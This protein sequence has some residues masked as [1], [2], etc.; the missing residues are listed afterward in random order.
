MASVL[1]FTLLASANLFSYSC[2]LLGVALV[3]ISLAFT[4]FS[5]AISFS[6]A[7]LDTG[8]FIGVASGFKSFIAFSRAFV[9]FST[10]SISEYLPLSIIDTF[11]AS[12]RAFSKAVFLSSAAVVLRFCTSLPPAV[13]TRLCKTSILESS[14]LASLT[15]LSISS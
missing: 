5:A 7:V 2:F 1:S 15:S 9:N 11:L 10:S 8:A 4:L 12:V 3:Y 14:C 13:E 6:R